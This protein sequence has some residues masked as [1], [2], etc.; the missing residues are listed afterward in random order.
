MLKTAA[1]KVAWVGRIAFM[2]FALAAVLAGCSGVGSGSAT[3]AP[4]Q[5]KNDYATTTEG[6]KVLIRMVAND[7]GRDLQIDRINPKNNTKGDIICE[8]EI[9]SGLVRSCT[10][11]PGKGFTGKDQ[12]PYVV[13]DKDGRTDEARVLV[14]VKPA[15]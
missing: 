5:A 11:K 10:Y 15:N 13:K 4:P 3:P 9:K 12:F 6:R 1:S 14:R 2:V 7:T 8:S